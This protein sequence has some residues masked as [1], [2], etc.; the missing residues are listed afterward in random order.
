MRWLAP[1]ICV[2]AAVHLGADNSDRASDLAA[3]LQRASER[4]EQYLARAQTI[5]CLEVV[6][7]QPLTSGWSSDGLGRTVESELRVSWKPGE[8]GEASAEA[9]TLRQLLKVNGRKPRKNDLDSCTTP[10]QEAEE[11]QALSLLLPSQLP[12]YRFRLAGE[13]RVDRRPAI[14][15]DYQLVKTVSVESHMVEGRDDCISFNL[16]G[17]TQGRLWIDVETFEVLRLDQRL[18]SMVDIPLPK[19]VRRRLDG[20][21]IWTMERWDSSIRFRLVTFTNPDESLVVPTSLSSL[22]ILRGSGAPRLRTTTDYKN[23][24]RYLT[25]GRVVGG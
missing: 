10:E 20:P 11:P 5:V 7:L 8:D 12:D 24:Q 21:A 16:E 14:M 1:T 18:T 6:H 22:Q 13:S 2:V 23:Y 19:P 3:I 4:V 17:G 9:Q 25:N 15:I